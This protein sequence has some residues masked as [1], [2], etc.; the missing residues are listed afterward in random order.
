MD[1]VNGSLPIIEIDPIKDLQN[2]DY[3][4]GEFK[5]QYNFFNN[6]ISDANQQGLF[7]KEISVLPVSVKSIC[8]VVK[9]L[10]PVEVE[11]INVFVGIIVP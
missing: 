3:T 10:V 8:C 7:I 9:N 4:S 5:V 6:T 1:P 11:V 2:L